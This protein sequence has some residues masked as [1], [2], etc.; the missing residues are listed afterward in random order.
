MASNDGHFLPWELLLTGLKCDPPI[1]SLL[2]FM[3]MMGHAFTDESDPAREY[4]I[5]ASLTR[6]DWG[7]DMII[8]FA[9]HARYKVPQFDEVV[10]K[11]DLSFWRDRK[12][13]V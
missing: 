2:P 11:R 7:R 13:V 10:S 9:Q 1:I 3:Q 6:F 8:A 4:Y 12:S 5:N